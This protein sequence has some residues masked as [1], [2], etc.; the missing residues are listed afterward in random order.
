IADAAVAV[1]GSV[2]NIGARRLQTILEKVLEEVSF[3]A[4]DRSG[5]TLVVDAAYV[6]A[7]IGALSQDADLSRFI[8]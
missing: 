3:T 6:T 2:E 7:R 5:E 8:L 1:N 4:G